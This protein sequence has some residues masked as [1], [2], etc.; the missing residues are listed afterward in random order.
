[1]HREGRAAPEGTLGLRV[2]RA[3]RGSGIARPLSAREMIENGLPHKGLPD[4]VNDWRNDNRANILGSVPKLLVARHAARKL[5]LPF[6]WSQLWLV[7]V[8]TFGQRIPLGLAS[9]RLVTTAGVNYLVDSFQGSVEPENMRFHGI[10]TGAT[11]EAVGDTALVTELTTQYDPDNTRAT[12]TRIEG[13]SANIYRTVGLNT[14]DA[15]V[16]IT[17][18]GIFSV[19]TSGSGVL[20]DRSVFTA[21]SLTSGDSLESTYDF[22]IAA[23]S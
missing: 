22:T 15:I 10:G 16:D 18:H 4:E 7:K 2:I 23:G 1:M 9:V 19:V 8:D 6:L 14:V 17:E 5:G 12:G 3:S 11:A 20:L 13:A 21:V